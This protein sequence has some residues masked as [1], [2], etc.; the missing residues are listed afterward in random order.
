MSMQR[1]VDR[2]SSTATPVPVEELTI[3]YVHAQLLNGTFTYAQLVQAYLQVLPAVQLLCC[4]SWTV[5][6]A[7][8]AALAQ[9]F[10]LVPAHETCVLQ[11]IS[12]YDKVTGLNSVYYI[13]PDALQQAGAMDRKLA[14]M[15]LDGTPLPSLFCIPFILKVST[16]CSHTMKLYGWQAGADAAVRTSPAPTVL[17]PL[18][19]QGTYCIFALH[20]CCADASWLRKQG[21]I[22]RAVLGSAEGDICA[23]HD[24]IVACWG[25]TCNRQAPVLQCNQGMATRHYSSELHVLWST[26]TG[27][28]LKPKG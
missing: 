10:K 25:C 9:Q 2:R 3:A 1:H 11:R 12:A 19:P 24:F 26:A 8:T 5:S 7:T 14:Q 18:H 22:H 4:R 28:R 20:Q 13:Y 6:S 16:A 23:D 27:L 21:S 15:Q 17:H